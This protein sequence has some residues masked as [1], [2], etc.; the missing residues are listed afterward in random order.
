MDNDD[1][2]RSVRKYFK[3]PMAE[4]TIGDTLVLHACTVVISIFVGMSIQSWI[5]FI[6]KVGKES[7]V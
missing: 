1:E 6:Q 5:H 2:D 4:T 3:K 7:S